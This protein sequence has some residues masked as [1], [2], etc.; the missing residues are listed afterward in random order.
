[1]YKDIFT[2][3]CVYL[4]IVGVGNMVITYSKMV[5]EIG[6]SSYEVNVAKA[7]TIETKNPTMREQVEKIV[8]AYFPKDRDFNYLMYD[9]QPC[10]NIDFNP[11]AK[12]PNA[13]KSGHATGL[14]Q[15]TTDTW[16]DGIKRFR[17]TWTMKDITDPLKN[18]EM[19]M[20]YWKAGESWR[21]ECK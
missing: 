12:N 4:F 9:V 18:T 6:H 1:M 11:E 10:E 17:P 20:E 2:I 13:T 19:A 3:V 15:I 7:E 14:W 5:K 8:R 16:S 21:W